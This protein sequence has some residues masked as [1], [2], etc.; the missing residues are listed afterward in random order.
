MLIRMLKI[1]KALIRTTSAWMATTLVNTLVVTLVDMWRKKE[2]DNESALNKYIDNLLNDVT[3]YVPIVRDL[4]SILQGYSIKR[5][6]YNGVEKIGRSITRTGKY[7]Q[8]TIDG[9]RKHSYPLRLIT[10]DW[11]ESIAYVFGVGAINV[12]REI[13]AALRNYTRWINDDGVIDDI[14]K[15]MFKK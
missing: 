10:K 14:Y 6:E 12:N 4:Y 2:D 15:F 13:E 3:G 9:K 1:K 7:V 5:M 8:E 11:I